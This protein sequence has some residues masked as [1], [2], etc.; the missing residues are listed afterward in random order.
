MTSTPAPT[1][2][3]RLPHSLTGRA[4]FVLV[5]GALGFTMNAYP[6]LLLGGVFLALGQIPG[7][8]CALL[9]G[10]VAGLFG[11]ALAA[12]TLLAWG[13]GLTLTFAL[14]SF[15][16]MAVGYLARRYRPVVSGLVYWLVVGAPVMS[17]V[18]LVVR[19]MSV[20]SVELVVAKNLGGCLFNVAVA[21]IIAGRRP[22]SRARDEADDKGHSIVATLNNRI[23]AILAIP[24][25]LVLIISSTVSQRTAER[26]AFAHLSQEAH[27]YRSTINEYVNAHVRTVS[28]V[29][30]SLASAAVATHA[31]RQALLTV[32]HSANPG[33]ITMLVADSQ[34]VVVEAASAVEGG[35]PALALIPNVRDRPYFAEPMRTSAPYVSGIFQGRSLGRDLIFAVSAPV[36]GA[37]GAPAGVV[38]GSIP[39][40]ALERI[41]ADPSDVGVTIIDQDHRVVYS[42]R[43][44]RWKPLSVLPASIA[45]DSAA[46]GKFWDTA[47]DILTTRREQFYAVAHADHGWSVLTVTPRYVALER[48]AAN[49]TTLF[50]ASAVL[51]AVVLFSVRL[52]NNFLGR[53]LMQLEA[54]AIALDWGA[55]MEAPVADPLRDP[56]PRE[57]AVVGEAMV[58]AARRIHESYLAA[59]QAVADRDVALA[60]R[61][62]TL[63]DLDRLVRERTQEL[64]LQRDRA[65]SANRAK[66]AF[67]A[68]MSH[69]LRTPLNVIL[70][71]S[72]SIV[73]GIFGPVSARQR[74]ALAEVDTQGQHLLTLINEVLDLA[75]IESGKF[76]VEMQPTSLMPLLEDVLATFIQTAR[77]R[78]VLLALE[79]APQATAIST[80]RLRLRQVLVNL[81][82]NALKFTPEGGRV[83]M[84][85]D[86]QA[87]SGSP[88]AIR[89]RDTGI[90]IP[91]NRLGTI[92]DAFE[93]ADSSNTRKFGG[94]G[95]GLTISR[96]LCEAMGIRID[97]ESRSGSGSTF[98]LT[99]AKPA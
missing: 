41:I 17:F 11:S 16:G 93:Q 37:R 82:G 46:V 96:S 18:F 24:V 89:I 9:F 39:L 60:Q 26:T 69:E 23:G 31:E 59:Q 10:P 6:V 27:R 64:I 29:A 84:E 78:G 81:V 4:M 54:Q 61:E 42:T 87:S 47:P 86:V 56:P 7:L 91:R 66:S 5:A 53:P 12:G 72:E 94:S 55:P 35:L 43:T 20:E 67:L 75:R 48:A 49:G 50:F 57:V 80:D 85:L 34:G 97:V 28:T 71:Q 19:G 44:E 15:E 73:E 1:P 90:G 32:T 21:S 79:A 77:Q 22:F 68:N 33:F 30:S 74:S 25:L 58:V 83:T 13:Q 14:L 88:V 95:L 38:E 62:A 2:F 45:G 8:V 36:A 40:K 98:T 3:F 51:F 52:V 92:F 99:F 65:E 63:R 70:G 76:T